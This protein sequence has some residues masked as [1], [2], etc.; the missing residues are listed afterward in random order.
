MGVGAKEYVRNLY[1]YNEWANGLVLRAASALSEEQLRE[2]DGVSMGS[3]LA[4]LSHVA[5]AQ[6]RWLAFWRGEDRPQPT[7]APHGRALAWLQDLYGPSHEELRGFVEGLTDEGLGRTLER[8]DREGK[9]HGWAL[10]QLMAH[11]ANHGTQHRSETAV[12]LTALGSSPGDL[13]YGHFCDIR[14][15]E[16][17]G[18]LAMMRTLCEY[19]EW[20]NNRVLEA[21]AGLSDDEMMRP[22]GVSHGSLGMDLLHQL[23]GQ[24]GWLSTWQGGAPHISLPSAEGASFLENLVGWFRRSD[25]A[26]REFIDSL[27][28]REL[29]QPRTDRMPGG[30]ERT[31]MLW[32]MM[33]H[34]VNHGTQH[35]SEAAMALT[36]L[37]R[38]P[39]DLDFLDFVDLRA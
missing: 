14:G 34:V 10:W 15:S 16:A 27:P 6:V 1:A 18:T 28:E 3:S 22:L 25:A 29:G 20:A 12:A 5:W 24:V 17:P 19:N 13:D 7:E 32:D 8:T 31:M 30:R 2:E 9:T 33:A 36:A 35:R 26:I 39:G 21:T 37:G 4:N 38:S 23:G 11:V